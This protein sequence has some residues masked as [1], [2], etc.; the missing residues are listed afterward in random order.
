MARTSKSHKFAR[1]LAKSL[2]PIT[3]APKVTP[4]SCEY[5]PE[6]GTPWQVEEFRALAELFQVAPLEMPILHGWAAARPD[7]EAGWT[8]AKLLYSIR[9]NLPKQN[10]NPDLME[11]A[12]SISEIAERL[13][14]DDAGVDA[15]LKLLAQAWFDFKRKIP[16]DEPQTALEKQEPIQR[17]MPE[18]AG[19][20][21]SPERMTELKEAIK[22]RGFNLKM[23]DADPGRTPEERQAEMQWF[24]ERLLELRKVFDEPMAKSLARQ[25]ILNELH[26][27]RID[28]MLICRTPLG[29]GFEDLLKTKQDI[30][31]VYAT[32][33]EQL[34][35]ICPFV[36]GAVNKMTVNGSIGEFVKAHWQLATQ[37]D[38]RL[39]DGLYNAYGFMIEQRQSQQQGIRDRPGWKAAVIEA[40]GHIWDPDYKREIPDS[41]CRMMDLAW[42][43]AAVAI[44]EKHGVRLP[45]LLLD[46]PGGE[47]D[48]IIRSITMEPGNEAREDS[49]RVEDVVVAPTE[50]VALEAPPE[51]KP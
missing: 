15:E 49:D 5:L 21:P 30:E 25:A 26:L 11:G 33:W 1:A 12:L 46:G 27:Q 37:N 18:E 10:T 43:A 23:F 31:K 32:Q 20:V 35:T 24:G 4:A 19:D 41:V 42:Q 22:A 8:I 36:K 7:L 39:V 9:P 51:T 34:E 2:R 48:E 38:R 17:L 50:S 6:D 13:K 44:N 29:E 40:M 28:N 47:Y 16:I 45:N 3:P 14:T